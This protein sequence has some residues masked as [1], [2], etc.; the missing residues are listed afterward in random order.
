MDIEQKILNAKKK[1]VDFY[2]KENGK[3]FIAFSGGKDSQV[4]LHLARSIYPD[5]IGVFSNTT[6]E[7][8]NVLDNVKKFNN[9]ITVLPKIN[10]IKTIEKYGF[11][12]VSKEVSQK[13]YELKHT[14]GKRTFAIRKFGYQNHP[15]SMTNKLNS[16]NEPIPK[17]GSGKCPNKWQFLAEEQ[18]DINSKCCDILKKNP[19]IKFQKENNL[20]PIIALMGDES[21]LRMQLKLYGKDDDKKSYPFLKTGWTESDIWE[22]AEKFNIRFAECYYDRYI[23][24]VFITAEKRTG[25]EFCAFGIHLE[26]GNRL[27]RVKLESP[28]RFEKIMATLNNGISFK[29]AIDIYNK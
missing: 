9:I 5:I 23:E 24:D 26:K 4:L 1:I 8:K 7:N 25:C 28:R 20:K 6:N 21:K 2:E 19:M 11:P 27:D 16:K 18:F 15:D 17:V 29:E 12:L 13:V 10:F 14:K 22:Y 3:V